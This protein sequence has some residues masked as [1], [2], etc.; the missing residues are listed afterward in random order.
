MAMHKLTIRYN[1]FTVTTHFELNGEPV[2]S[3][4]LIERSKSRRLLQWIDKIFAPLFDEL[5][6]RDIDLVFEGTKLDAADVK[7]AI[8]RFM[9]ENRGLTIFDEYENCRDVSVD[10]KVKQLKAL[11]KKAQAGPF[12]EFRS[13][14]M[15]RAFKKA[16]APEFEV[17]VLATMSAGKSTVINA[18]LGKELMPSKNE[19]CTAT[20][21]KVYDFD[22]MDGFAGRRF[23]HDGEE[24][25]SWT[26]A[27]LA[28]VERWNEDRNTSTIEINGNIPAIKER[29]G[30][31]VVLVDT[32]GPN[33]SLDAMHRKAT[34]RAIRGRQPSM[35]LYILNATQLSTEDDQE[36]LVLIKE[37]MAEGG[38][39]AQ[40]RFIFVANK[41]DNFDPEKGESISSALS[42]VRKYLESN[43]IHN[44]LIIPTSAELT[45]LLRVAEFEGHDA[46]SR[47]Q[48]GSL[49][50]FVDLFIEEEDMNM[51]EHVKSDIDSAIYRRLNDSLTDHRRADNR[52]SC[53]AILSGIPIIEA[54]LDNYIAKHAI[55]SRIKDAVD[56]F[57]T[58]EGRTQATQK[59]SEI[60]SCGEHEL[61][62]I[63]E[64]IAKFNNDKKRV[65]KAN[66]FRNNVES[67][68]YSIS[69][70]S[71]KT[72]KNIDRKVNALLDELASRF[73][74]D[75]AP[76]EADRIFR[77]AERQA[78]TLVYEIQEL[79]TENLEND[80]LQTLELL[81]Q[82]Y[83]TY[84]QELLDREF[85][86]GKK[87]RLL[88][89]FQAASLQMPDVKALVDEATYEKEDRVFVRTERCG[90]LWLKKRDV[91]KSTYTDMVDMSG[92]A[93]EL[94]E[95]LQ[96]AKVEN[97]EL[98]K[99]AGIKNFEIAKQ[100]LL[101]QMDQID[102]K[103]RE[104]LAGMEKANSDHRKQQQIINDCR[105]RIS[106]YD[107]FKRELDAILAI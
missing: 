59:I 44:P 58:I 77:A 92:P 27:N 56:T 15:H 8:E 2:V 99:A 21:S 11:F 79:L 76:S 48:R 31:R 95:S 12:A 61:H 54:L 52:S 90:F 62:E 63:N 30:V 73:S 106:W 98:S 53:A 55:P 97:F 74:H 28:L 72:R 82:D 26:P 66:E 39:E 68:T 43:G 40:D 7:D 78:S 80:L 9:K 23:G 46:L 91:Y 38:R 13:E 24:L 96:K 1:P 107:E 75:V 60:M 14:E 22:E 4:H 42:N 33:N 10:E 100:T 18:M 35:V 51:L 65:R 102:E 104:T 32:P 67:M 88:R 83:Q 5:N 41:I 85:P 103:L 57:K 81:R 3:G 16:L 64:A 19:A 84:V 36:L 89:D 71:T 69:P 20:I 47:K 50:A 29:E 93:K 25:D 105:Q 37:A 101:K 70:V 94:E 86:E 87:M 34:I 17:S 45:K 6:T 49:S